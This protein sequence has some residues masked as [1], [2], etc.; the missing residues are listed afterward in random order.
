MSDAVVLIV[1]L[2]AALPFVHPLQQLCYGDYDMKQIGSDIYCY[3]IHA[4]DRFDLPYLDKYF[5]TTE[6]DENYCRYT[7]EHINMVSHSVSIRTKKEYEYVKAQY[8]A[9]DF[10]LTSVPLLIGLKY[11]NDRFH[12]FDHSTFN[13]SDFLEPYYKSRFYV[14]K[15]NQCRR[16]FMYSPPTFGRRRYYVFDINCKIRFF[17]F[18]V[19]CRYKVPP[20]SI[21]EKL[22]PD[23][24]KEKAV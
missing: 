17:E 13:Y 22:E 14:L 4:F 8:R 23:Y 12:W 6:G 1:Y 20:E 15:K 21:P 16:F 19:L 18:R 9:A 3:R 7:T 5:N 2:A 24:S 11:E 10:S